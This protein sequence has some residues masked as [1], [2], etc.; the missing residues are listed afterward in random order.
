MR[1]FDWLFGKRVSPYADLQPLVIQVNKAA[2]AFDD[3]RPLIQHWIASTQYMSHSYH[4]VLDVFPDGDPQEIAVAQECADAMRDAYL[5]LDTLHRD[6]DAYVQATR[7]LAATLTEVVG[8][9]E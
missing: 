6:T 3:A 8:R 1:I 2:Q 9:K 7:R 4:F 5:T